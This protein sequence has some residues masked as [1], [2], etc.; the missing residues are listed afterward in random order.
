MRYRVLLHHNRLRRG[1]RGGDE[2]GTVSPYLDRCALSACKYPRAEWNRTDEH[3]YGS[4]LVGP[5]IRGASTCPT[6]SLRSSVRGEALRQERIL[7]SEYRSTQSTQHAPPALIFAWTPFA[8]DRWSTGE[9][10]YRFLTHECTGSNTAA[11]GTGDRDSRA[12]ARHLACQLCEGHGYRRVWRVEH[13][14]P[15]PSRGDL[16]S[17]RAKLKR[18]ARSAAPDGVHPVRQRTRLELALVLASGGADSG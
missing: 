4:L 5:P 15:A 10:R 6:R 3:R 2:R 11:S 13:R 1:D 18:P 14:T 12:G 9:R 17:A 16:P 8:R 7:S